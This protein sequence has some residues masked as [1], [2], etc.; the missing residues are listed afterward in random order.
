M[1]AS[2]DLVDELGSNAPA[3][4][5]LA[6]EA[7]SLATDAEAAEHKDRSAIGRWVVV[8]FDITTISN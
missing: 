6:A 5:L 4:Q 1:K 3:A 2:H 8:V 7:E